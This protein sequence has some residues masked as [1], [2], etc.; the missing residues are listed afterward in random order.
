MKNNRAFTLVELMIVVAIIGILAAV[1]LP[2][3]LTYVRTSKTAEAVSN[4]RKVYDGEYNYY[5]ETRT[6]RTG[7]QSTA[8][9]VACLP[10]PALPPAGQKELANWDDPTWQAI[11]FDQDSPVMYSYSVDI[12]GSGSTASFTAR[13]EGDLD[14]DGVPSLFE[15]IGGIDAATGEPAGG[16]ALYISRPIE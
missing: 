3:F 8:E 11:Q 9:F 12:G 4:I 1:A 15:R 5:F 7:V 16:S 14:G 13:A 10:N 2:A 6:S